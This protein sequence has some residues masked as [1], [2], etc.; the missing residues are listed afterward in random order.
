MFHRI[1]DQSIDCLTP[2]SSGPRR[3]GVK[4]SEHPGPHT[5][6]RLLEAARELF[7]TR[8]YAA[9]STRAIASRAGC[10]IALINHY[11][12]SKDGLLRAA[13]AEPFERVELELQTLLEQ[14]R[15]ARDRLAAFIEFMVDHFATHQRQVQINHAELSRE[16]SPIAEEIRSRIETNLDLLT[17]L[18]S[19]VQEEGPL[20]SLD[21]RTLGLLLMGSLQMFFTTHA[22]NVNLFNLNQPDSLTLLKANVTGLF[23]SQHIREVPEKC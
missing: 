12:G 13:S 18:I 9:A 22:A 5:R 19:Q 4:P 21:P 23:L 15:P 10:N 3:P 11:F 7:S 6:S 2:T 8:G 17:R 14:K 16:H 1:M 20:R